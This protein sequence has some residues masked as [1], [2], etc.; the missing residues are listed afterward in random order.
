MFGWLLAG[1]TNQPTPGS[2]V[3]SHHTLIATGDDLLRQF[4]EIEE[5]PKHESN[6]SPEERFVVQHFDKGHYR[7]ADGRF[8]VP[9]PKKPRAP[10][11]GESRSHAVRRFLSLERSLHAKGEFKAFDA[12]IQEYFELK[13]AEPVPTTDLDKPQHSV[14][15]LPMH[16]VKKESST[17][18]KIRA[19]FDASAKSSSNISLNDI[20][21]VGPTIH[22]SL[23]DVLLRFR[24]H[25]IALT[26]DVS[27]MYRAVELIDSDRDLHRFVWRSNEDEPLKDY[28]MTRVTFGVSASSFAANTSV[29]R[30]ALDHALEF[31]KAADAVESAFYVDDCLMG[32]DS[33]DEAIGLHH[34]LLNLLAKG[35]F[36]LRKWSSS[37][38]AVLHH[39]SPE[40]RD[41]QSTHHIPSPDGYT[42]TLGIEW[43]ANLDL[44][45]ASLQDT[46]NVTKRA[47]ISDIAKTFDALGWFSHT[48]IKAKILLQRLWESRIGWDDLLPP[49]IYQSWL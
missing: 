45:V 22:S 48:I 32:V 1:S 28:R 19:V 49:A 21:L 2:F 25:R 35:G 47:L 3:T 13:H 11:L 36:L 14:F 17:T 26:A 43:N 5:N 39:I 29:K 20:L 34:Q 40:L 44:T 15:Y 24:L 10:T 37:D 33:I 38:P 6:L 9:L 27:K 23:I 42:K 18:T 12:V 46:D 8:V 7:A 31:P 4:W 30:N 16:A 41:T